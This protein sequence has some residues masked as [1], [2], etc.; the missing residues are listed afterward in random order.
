MAQ[1]IGKYKITKRESTLSIIDGGTVNDAVTLDG[2][3]VI[4]GT[5]TLS[6]AA[7]SLTGLGVASASLGASNRLFLTSSAVFA[8]SSAVTDAGNF[9]VVCMTQ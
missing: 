9:N 4:T 2:T 1:R 5:T 8:S 3:T 7:I 6:S